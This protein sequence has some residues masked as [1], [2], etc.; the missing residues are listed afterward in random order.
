MKK[1]HKKPSKKR[2]DIGEPF[3]KAIRIYLFPKTNT[4]NL[5]PAWNYTDWVRFA[6]AEQL[7][8]SGEIPNECKAMLPKFYADLDL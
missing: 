3:E 2:I 7:K 5:S 1:I 4:G 8:R 6:I